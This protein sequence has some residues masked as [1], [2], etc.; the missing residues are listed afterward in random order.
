MRALVRLLRRGLGSLALLILLLFGLQY[1]TLPF[2]DAWTAVALIVRDHQFDYVGWELRAISAKIEQTLWGRHPFISEQNRSQIVRDYMADLAQVQGL[3]AQIDALFADPAINDPESASADLR[4]QRD[5]ARADL[6]Q[7]QTLAES[8]LEGQVAAVLIDEGFGTLGQLLP[9]ISMRFT[10]VPNLLIVSPRDAIR[11]DISINIDP[12]PVDMISALEAQI[13]RQQDVSSLIV[14]LGGIAL[15]PAMIVE[16]ASIP[17]AVDVFAHEW[18]H[19]YLF[20]FPLG[21]NYDFAGETRI[22]NETTASIFGREIAARV[23]RR[24]YPELAPPPT[25]PRAGP[26]ADHAPAAFDFGREMDITRRRVDDLLAQ[27]KVN[28]AETYMEERRQLFYSNGYQIRK[29]NQAFF[30]FYGGYQAEGGVAGAGG[31]DP[32]GEAVQGLLDS[33]LSLQDWI[34]AM[35]AIITREELIEQWQRSQSAIQ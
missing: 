32:I 18:L 33:S 1:S 11:F 13:D 29:L 31:A 8:I 4:R 9:P 10:Q 23:L 14:P 25:P 3:E 35:R 17:R 21:L 5:E 28:E 15:Y 30:A 16:T 24:Y 20:A 22:I 12:L 34:V 2:G 27:G 19:H 6:Q 7:R 26:S